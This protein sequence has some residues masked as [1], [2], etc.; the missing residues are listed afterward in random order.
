M[1]FC[2]R[3]HKGLAHSVLFKNGPLW[4][5]DKQGMKSQWPHCPVASWFFLK[6]ISCFSL[7][8]PVSQDYVTTQPRDP[9]A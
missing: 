1:Q 4:L 3:V 2:V 8:V 9:S 6:V 5:P 7:L